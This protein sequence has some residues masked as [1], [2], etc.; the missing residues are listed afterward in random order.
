[1]EQFAIPEEFAVFPAQLSARQNNNFRFQNWPPTT[2][3]QERPKRK[4]R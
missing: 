2:I 1:M 3:P 4:S